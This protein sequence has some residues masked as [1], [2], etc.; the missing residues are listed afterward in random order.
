MKKLYYIKY[1]KED[2]IIENKIKSL[3]RTFKVFEGWVVESVIDAKQ[4]HAFITEQ[5]DSMS[6]IVFGLDRSNYYGRYD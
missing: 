1:F 6:I 5:N 4:I 2:L 3:G